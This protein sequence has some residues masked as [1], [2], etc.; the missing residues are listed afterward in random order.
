[1]KA[2]LFLLFALLVTAPYS[3][4]RNCRVSKEFTLDHPQIL[5]GAIEAPYGAVIPGMKMELL[6][7]KKVIRSVHTN[8]LGQYDFAEVPI[9]KYRLRVK[10][11]ADSFCAPPIDCG[12][13][14]CSI[15]SKASLDPKKSGKID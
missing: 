10:D 1:M 5:A 15:G 14:H 4:A 6:S 2:L 3:A 7:G 9:G 12:Q 13:E 11:G 8:N